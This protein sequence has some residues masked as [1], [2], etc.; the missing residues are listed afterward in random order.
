VWEPDE[1]LALQ[2]EKLD[3]N[4]APE[5]LQADAI[6]FE[7]PPDMSHYVDYRHLQSLAVDDESTTEVDDALAIVEE[8]NGDRTVYVFI[9]DAAAWVNEGDP[10]DEEA[11]NRGST[12]YIPE[13]KVPMLPAQTGQHLASLVVGQDRGA[14]AFIITLNAEGRRIGF[15]VQE[16]LIQVDAQLTYAEVDRVLDGGE[17]PYKETLQSLSS[18]AEQVRAHRREAGAMILDRLEVSVQVSDG[19]AVV[20]SYSTDDRSR[21]LVSEWMIA[22]C[23]AT[24]EMCQERQ[25]PAVYRI[26]EA[27]SPRPHIPSDRLLT[28]SEL[29]RVLRTM[30]RAEL[31]TIASPHAGL[32]V[33][34]YT[35][36]TS[37]LRRY[38]DLVMHRQLKG[39]LRVGNAPWNEGKLMGVFEPVE[40]TQQ[41]HGRIERESC[42]Y[43][44][45][46]SLESRVGEQVEVEVLR[47]AGRRVIVE[48]LENHLQCAWSP[49]IK[50]EVG[51][52]IPLKILRVNARKDRLALGV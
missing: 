34:C 13:G 6:R 7:N 28:S 43:W 9:A 52:R 23:A 15:E 41:L 50:V 39:Y 16:C 45:L 46:K 42:R 21:C 29:I 18:A 44:L 17:S 48:I 35:Q 8:D 30:R 25:I 38:Q 10:L 3:L 12:L 47:E 14:M 31:S 51:Q 4:F 32:G 22:A 20:W 49:E 26:Q 5:L 40:A 1:N 37:P 36:V 24:A 2:R 33:P 19:S 11:M 27:P